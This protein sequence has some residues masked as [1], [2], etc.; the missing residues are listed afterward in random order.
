MLHLSCFRPLQSP[1]KL[2]A[3]LKELQQA[4]ERERALTTETER[5]ARD[6]QTKLD[7]LSRVKSS[8]AV[9]RCILASDLL[10]S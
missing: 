4:V 6:L 10:L 5:R 7:T 3:A 1:E 9:P 2:E 8:S